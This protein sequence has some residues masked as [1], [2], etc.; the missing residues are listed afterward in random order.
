[1]QT[2]AFLA[3]L[4]AVTAVLGGCAGAPDAGT[5][6]P[7]ESTTPA[8]PTSS[9][10]TTPTATATPLTSLPD[11]ERCLTDA[12]PRPD[13]VDGVEPSTYPTPPTNTSQDRVVRWV[14]EFETAYFRNEIISDASGF[15]DRNLTSVT[16][17][18]EVYGVTRTDEGYVLRLGDFGASNYASGIHGDHWVDVGYVVNETHLVRVPLDDREDPV[19]PSEGMAVVACR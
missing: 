7:N 8:T 14:R 10:P 13:R 19:R 16:A 5:P 2:D 1:M 6:V 17:S 12:V 3:L 9:T 4:L 15:D 11:A 18:A